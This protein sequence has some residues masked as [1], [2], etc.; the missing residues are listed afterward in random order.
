[1]ATPHIEAEPGSIAPVVLLPGDP[2]RAEWIAENHLDDARQV[3]GVRNMLGFT[4]TVSGVPVSVMGSGMGVPSS[5]IYATELI[6]SYD[7]DR[8]IRVGSCG[9]LRSD[10][11]L[12]QLIL[13][14]GAGT[15][16]NINRARIGGHDFPAVAD[17]DLLAAADE[18]ARRRQVEVLVGTVFT[19]DLFYAPDGYYDAA[20]VHGML[21]VE[22][23]TA[24]LYGVGAA[25]GA[26][27]LSILTVSDN[28]ITGERLS[29]EDRQSGFDAMVAMALDVAVGTSE[30]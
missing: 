27:M 6:R 16:S 24:G 8:I 22:M 7:V 23:E 3:T 14:I 10:V 9:G 5:A 18:A 20:A 17:F 4:G 13:A 12:N 1:M 19:S 26:R 21:A 15:D 2:L 25:E 29:T 11:T 28:L 30:A